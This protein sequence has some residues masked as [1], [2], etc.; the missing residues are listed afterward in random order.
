MSRLLRADLRLITSLI[1]EGAKVLDIGCGDGALLAELRRKRRIAGQG[2][3]LSGEGVRR[4][5]AAGLSVI[6]GDADT[7]LDDYPA[8][9]F[10]FVVLSQTIQATHNPAKVLKNLLRIGKAAVV[11]FPNFGHWKTRLNLAWRGRMPLSADMSYAWHS[12]PNIHPCTIADFRDLCRENKVVIQKA[13]VPNGTWKG[14]LSN[15]LDETAVFLV[16]KGWR[17]KRSGRTRKAVR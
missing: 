9:S 12:T 11:S 2:I 17:Q 15:L 8:A 7:D 13:L 6:Q 1:P 14:A 3:E 4:C 5:L 16:T 10:D